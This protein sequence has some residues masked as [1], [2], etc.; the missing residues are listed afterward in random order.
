[1]ND[2]ASNLVNLD[3]FSKAIAKTA[4]SNK[5]ILSYSLVLLKSLDKE[6]DH[7]LDHVIG[8]GRAY[9]HK[10]YLEQR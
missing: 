9:F 7:T 5:A 2:I 3:S 1:M 10:N 8:H 4:E 6:A